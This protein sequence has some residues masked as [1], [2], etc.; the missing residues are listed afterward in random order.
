MLQ[1]QRSFHGDPFF[2]LLQ[3]VVWLARP[4]GQGLLSLSLPLPHP[5]MAMVDGGGACLADGYGEG[6]SAA[7]A[8][9]AQSARERVRDGEEVG[10]AGRRYRSA[11]T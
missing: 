2:A 9:Y 7:R 10:R 5:L 1:R 8:R 11:L 4:A 3:E 6:L